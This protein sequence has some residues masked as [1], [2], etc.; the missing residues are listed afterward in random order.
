MSYTVKFDNCNEAIKHAYWY[1]RR[2]C[3]ILLRE[4]KLGNI[5]NLTCAE[6]AF[7][8]AGIQGYPVKCIFERWQQKGFIRK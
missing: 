7:S 2:G 6:M 1:N 4:A 3:R 5:P 8:F